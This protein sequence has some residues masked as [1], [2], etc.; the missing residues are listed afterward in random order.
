M[1]PP[2][3]GDVTKSTC[4]VCNKDYHQTFDNK[5]YSFDGAC[6]YILAKV[7]NQF[8]V[9]VDMSH[10]TDTNNCTKVNFIDIIYGACDFQNLLV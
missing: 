4:F 3:V 10:C 7:A 1:I 9:Q 2:D 6:R 8:E 5:A